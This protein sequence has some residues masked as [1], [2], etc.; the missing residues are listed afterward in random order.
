MDDLLR[1]F[2]AET[3]ESLDI[4]DV[5]LVRFEQN[6]NAL[7]FSNEDYEEDEQSEEQKRIEVSKALEE[8]QRMAAQSAVQVV[9]YLPQRRPVAVPAIV[10]VQP[11][12]LWRQPGTSP[13]TP[14]RRSAPPTTSST[15]T[16][17]RAS[18]G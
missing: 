11:V 3:N 8:Q 16:S 13:R 18:S 9:L 6:P 10:I 5:E 12:P 14:R 7:P 2:L 17:R 1:E 15:R 4:V